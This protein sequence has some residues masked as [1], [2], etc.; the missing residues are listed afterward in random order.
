MFSESEMRY[1]IEHSPEVAAEHVE[2]RQSQQ[3]HRRM[4][5]R[6]LLRSELSLHAPTSQL[7]H[8]CLT[9]TKD[10]GYMKQLSSILDDLTQLPVRRDRWGRYVVLPVDGAKP[11]GYTRAT[12]IAKGIEDSGGLLNWGK[13]MV[14]IGLAQRPDLVALV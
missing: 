3:I 6:A 9:L 5:L 10:M 7:A 4:S 13:R 2:A 12:T 11:I 1:A 14:A 8:C